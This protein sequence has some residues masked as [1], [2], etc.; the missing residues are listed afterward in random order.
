MVQQ[1][2]FAYYPLG[3]SLQKQTKTT[4]DQGDSQA[5]VKNI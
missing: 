1:A 5:R 4:K 2:K 3:I